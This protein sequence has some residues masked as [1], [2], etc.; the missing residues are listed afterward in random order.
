MKKI[1]MT[2]VFALS[3]TAFASPVGMKT[4][5]EQFTPGSQQCEKREHKNTEETYAKS[6]AV[7]G[8]ARGKAAVSKSV[9]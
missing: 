3:S 6:S 9:N 8:T 2:F 1:I 7:E 5:L 4:S